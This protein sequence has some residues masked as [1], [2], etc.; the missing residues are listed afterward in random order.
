MIKPFRPKHNI[1][2]NNGIIRRYDNSGKDFLSD[3][4]NMEIKSGKLTKRFGTSELS[5]SK[6][7]IWE[8]IFETTLCEENVL[9]MMSKNFRFYICTRF[10]EMYQVACINNLFETKYFSFETDDVGNG[11]T[12]TGTS[13][14]PEGKVSIFQTNKYIFVIMPDNVCFRINKFGKVAYG[15]NDQLVVLDIVNA[16]NKKLSQPFFYPHPDGIQLQ[17]LTKIAYINEAGVISPLSEEIKISEADKGVV[18]RVP[19][20]RS[21]DKEGYLTDKPTLIETATT[22]LNVWV[23][24]GLSFE[25]ASSYSGA[26]YVGTLFYENPAVVFALR[27][28]IVY[29]FVRDGFQ[30]E[31]RNNR[32]LCIAKG[33]N[34]VHYEI[35]DTSP[36]SV[37]VRKKITHIESLQL[38]F[39]LLHENFISLESIDFAY[40]N[41]YWTGRPYV[42]YPKSVSSE[43]ET[44]TSLYR[45]Y[46][47]DSRAID[48]YGYMKKNKS[49][50]NHYIVPE[51]VG[52]E[53]SS[54]FGDRIEEPDEKYRYDNILFCHSVTYNAAYKFDA[55]EDL[56]EYKHNAF[57]LWS[58]NGATATDLYND[59]TF[60]WE[61][62]QLKSSTRTQSSFLIE[63]DKVVDERFCVWN[64]GQILGKNQR[65]FVSTADEDV[66][67]QLPEDE[68]LKAVR[69]IPM[70]MLDGSTLRRFEYPSIVTQTISQLDK[71]VYNNDIVFVLNAGDIWLS[72]DT[73]LLKQQVKL[74]E[75]IVDIQPIADGC[76][77]FGTERVFRILP[78]GNFLVISEGRPSRKAK[79]GEG[80]IASIAKDNGI[81]IYTA[82]WT[83]F[84]NQQIRVQKISDAIEDKIFANDSDLVIVNDCVF[85][86]SEN[87]IWGFA[88]GG[89]TK[90]YTF[91]YKIHKLFAFNGQLLIYFIDNFAKIYQTGYN[92]HLTDRAGEL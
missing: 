62:E 34:V 90:K 80:F 26:S 1:Y 42:V 27:E 86:A 10:G 79:S 64:N 52:F 66:C 30:N 5:N 31:I 82:E 15:K 89:W 2:F 47:V 7:D 68:S 58:I 71:A 87:E 45:R 49:P 74:P 13:Y 23:K 12:L 32:N 69:H 37:R 51:S 67:Y 21:F 18:S 88:N 29:A 55:F 8:H 81:Y 3:M 22:E 16:T 53:G 70:C 11:D 75:T 35:E 4:N 50:F 14:S 48:L 19:I 65:Y 54:A 61:R 56:A 73:L 60:D 72:D 9:L 92:V 43:Y 39:A 33:L 41:N 20:K 78:E 24:N 6:K 77:A 25:R 84:G 63:S 44:N 36:W 46:T 40:L 83:Q 59:V 91:D 38:P 57:D 28:G 17:G 85:I 76:L